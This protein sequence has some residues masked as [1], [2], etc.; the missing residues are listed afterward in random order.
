MVST[1]LKNISQIGSFPQVGVKIE[2]IWNHH[3][4][5]LL[6]NNCCQGAPPT[7]APLQRPRRLLPCPGS[8]GPGRLLSWVK[9]TWI[10]ML[11]EQYDWYKIIWLV[12]DS[13]AGRIYVHLQSPYIYFSCIYIYTWLYDYICMYGWKATFLWGWHIFRG[14]HST[15]GQYPP[16]ND[17][18]S[19]GKALLSGDF[20]FRFGG[21]C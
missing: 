3:L 10:Q 18:I 15:S 13:N 20:F 16:G 14:K 2:N 6:M 9:I 1:H 4:V 21:I 8:W 17:H 7:L 12:Y 19:P 11:E 5:R